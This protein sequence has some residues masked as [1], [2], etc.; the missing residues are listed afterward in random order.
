DRRQRRPQPFPEN[1]PARPAQRPREQIIARALL[2]RE[3]VGGRCIGGPLG[4]VHL[5]KKETTQIAIL[6]PPLPDKA[7][8]EVRPGRRDSDI[9]ISILPWIERGGHGVPKSGAEERGFAESD[10]ALRDAMAPA[11]ENFALL[12]PTCLAKIDPWQRARHGFKREP[13]GEQQMSVSV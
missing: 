2:R 3:L 7:L 4:Q 6:N 13:Y 1:R 12:L 8:S 5:Q 11:P 10:G 9:A